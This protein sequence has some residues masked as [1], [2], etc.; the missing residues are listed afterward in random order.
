MTRG[1]S[2]PLLF[3]VCE[4]SKPIAV[5]DLDDTTADMGSLMIE[6]LNHHTGKSLSKRDITE[7]DICGIYGISTDQFYEYLEKDHII[8]DLAVLPGAREA[9]TRLSYDH[10]IVMISARHCFKSAL[11]RTMRWLKN[12][13]IPCDRVL[14]SGGP[15]KVF[16][17]EVIRNLVNSNG[18]NVVFD[19]SLANIYDVLDSSMTKLAY[20]PAQPWNLEGV[21]HS[22]VLRVRSLREAVE[23]Y[24]R[25]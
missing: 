4:L 23:Y 16:K 8:D 13:R 15:G 11:V 10:E 2:G 21:N 3:G 19:D 12:N 7:Y 20:V 9:I 25:E 14:I 5:V 6:C 22:D 24:Y 1:P 17:S 18:V